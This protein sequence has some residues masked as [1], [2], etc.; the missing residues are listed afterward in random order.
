MHRVDVTGSVA[1][2]QIVYSGVILSTDDYFVNSHGIY[3]H[4]ATLLQQAHWW[5]QRRGKVLLI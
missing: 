3:Q 1:C 5:N 2:R 4:D